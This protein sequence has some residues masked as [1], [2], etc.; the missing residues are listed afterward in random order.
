MRFRNALSDAA[1]REAKAESTDLKLADGGGLFLLVA[2]HASARI[3]SSQPNA[4]RPQ[5][6]D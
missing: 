6:S 1:I 3:P 4:E 5:A 2:N